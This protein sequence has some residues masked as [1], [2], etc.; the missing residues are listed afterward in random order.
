MARKITALKARRRFKQR[1]IVGLVLR[2]VRLF[3]DHCDKYVPSDMEW[4]CG[5]CNETNRRTKFYSFLNKCQECKRPPKSFICP[6]CG[7]VN[8]LDKDESASHPAVMTSVPPP[9]PPE[10]KAEIRARIRE[11]RDEQKETMGH[12][13]TMAGLN[14]ELVRLEASTE[15]L[16]KKSKM[17]ELEKD[18]S[19]FKAHRMGVDE[20]EERVERMLEK[21]YPNDP[22]KREKEMLTLKAWKASKV[23]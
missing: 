1:L 23:E 18:W 7:E 11:K 5:H 2:P 9:P 13:I 8:F 16:K 14:A 15:F 10:T 4:R 17:E 3:C 21:T 6:H 22:D 12:K 19:E 20:I